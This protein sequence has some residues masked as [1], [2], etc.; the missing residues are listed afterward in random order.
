M[1]LYRRNPPNASLE[2]ATRTVEGLVAQGP[3]SSR[4][5]TST[6]T[7]EMGSSRRKQ[8]GLRQENACLT[9]QDEE[10]I[11]DLAVIP[12]DL[13][14]P[15]S[16]VCSRPSRVDV[17]NSV[18]VMSEQIHHLEAEV[19]SKAKE[20][21][22]A[23]IRAE[24]SQ[25][26]MVHSEIVVASLSEE[27][28]ALREELANEVALCKRAEQQRNR[29]LENAEKL[30][31]AF[32]EY[33]T[34]VSVKLKEVVRNE[35]ALKERITSCNGERED[36]QMKFS[37]LERERDEL[38]ERIS[39][40]MVE[41]RQAKT[42]AS[43]RSDLQT[44]L[45]ET[46][47]QASYLDLQLREK[48]AD[49]RELV[50]LRREV[51]HLRTLTKNQEQQVTQ[52]LKDAQ[53][54]RAE[55]NSLEAILSLLHLREGVTGQ[56]C[57]NPCVLPP[58][59]YT[60]T[61]EILR[62]KPGEGYQ[63]LLPVMQ[64]MQI[65]RNKHNN[66]VER[67]QERLSRAQEEISSLQNTMAQKV[68]HHQNLQKQ[69]QDKLNQSADTEKELKRKSARVAALEKQLQ[70]K[71]SA[72]GQAALKNTALESQLQEKTNTLQYYQTLMS[73]R[74]REYQQALDKCQK[75]QDQQS[76]EHRHRIEMLQL[77]IEEAHSQL[78]EMEKGVTA[79]QQERDAARSAAE[80]LDRLKQ[81]MQVE[82]KRKDEQL[83]NLREQAAQSADKV[84]DLQ[85]T[86]LT[87]REEL[88]SQKQLM[89]EAKRLCDAELQ[90]SNAKVSSLQEK[91]HTSSLLC[92]STG[93]QNLQLQLSLQQQQN[94]LTENM[95]RIAELEESQSLLLSKVSSLERE[96]EQARASLQSEVK[97]REEH[98]QVKDKDLLHMN[99]RNT[100]LSQTVSNLTAEMKTFKGDLLM[101]NSE[102]QRLR[103]DVTTKSSQL[104]H[105]EENL[106]HT[107]TMLENKSHLV[108]DLEERLHRCE[109][110]KQNSIQRV[111]TLEE[112]LHTVRLEL[113][114]TLNQLQELQEVLQRTQTIA[115][116]RRV[117]VEKLTIK[118]SETQRELEHR[119]CEVLDLDIALKERQG[120]LQQ[121]AKLLGQLDVVIRDHRQEMNR[122]VESLQRQL[123][124]K[125][126]ELR[127]AQ[128]EVAG[129]RS[130]DSQELRLCLQKAQTL[131][132]ELEES[133][134]ECRARTKELDDARAQ[135]RER[136][137]K[138]C[139]VS[140]ELDL[141]GAHW[142]QSESRLKDTVAALEQE[143]EQ[144]RERHSK[145]LESLQ[146]TRGQ[147]LKVSEQMSSDMRSSQDQLATQ[148][149]QCQSQLQQAEARRENT[150]AQLGRTAAELG[151]ARTLAGHLQTQLDQVQ[152]QLCQSEA[153]VERSQSLYQQ[154]REH[155]SQLQF[156][157]E[158]LKVQLHIVQT[159]QLGSNVFSTEAVE[160]STKS[161]LIQGRAVQ[162]STDLQAVDHQKSPDEE[163]NPSPCPASR[164]DTA[165]SSSSSQVSHSGERSLVCDWLQDSHVDSSLDLPPSLKA[166][167]RKALA[168]PPSESSFHDNTVD[169]SWH[170]LGAMDATSDGSFDPLTY[171]VTNASAYLSLTE[172]AERE[173]E[174]GE[175]TLVGEDGDLSSLTGMLRFVNQTL[176]KQEVLSQ[177]SSGTS[178]ASTQREDSPH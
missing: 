46:K 4:S 47:K 70:E 66:Q 139:S 37:L 59:D 57:V 52:S 130:K 79:L 151:Q 50:S 51:E 160:T 74:Q 14:T 35:N 156:Q 146:Q 100:E 176:A 177:T 32:K 166:S 113:S 101:K 33:K 169:L 95:G 119:T 152:N 117:S 122:K 88:N 39:Q 131:H 67:L 133:R 105:L 172:G 114:E 118:L 149:Q 110:D 108:V 112:Q 106:Q 124:D 132:K 1:S 15:A 12:Y 159:A 120:E 155:N 20:L 9:E 137:V 48:N 36:L 94:M 109:A 65:E 158:E 175:S 53:Q 16:Q 75:S 84:F 30:K 168:A 121:R 125:E 44:Q 150:E 178:Q 99:Q 73:R 104:S 45:E 80:A 134:R 77:S 18:V 62:L 144:E 10:L 127:D 43:E 90:K 163:R 147:L 78:L 111:H 72:Y 116:E 7:M 164:M 141:K 102:L 154:A 60:R 56:F 21:K 2:G 148:L 143:L 140:E 40:L 123:E 89:E 68:S 161:P 17:Q 31:D 34:K 142:Q 8:G 55:L 85:S 96:L 63:H 87:C 126:R 24:C 86:L 23:E 98:T 173:H 83:R 61:A 103:R 171:N 26:A 153:K 22:A 5:R 135:M 25:E 92:S 157:V 11:S 42:C 82:M 38:K 28:E 97:T 167:L 19:E 128:R 58:V 107:K 54:C 71:T 3:L 69:L 27:M 170:A 138:L 162:E 6:E 115:D 49:S 136:D 145:E 165:A 13:P 29:A 76:S 91:L 64:L 174:S 93:E 41:V 81:E 129:A